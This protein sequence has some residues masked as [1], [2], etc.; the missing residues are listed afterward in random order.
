VSSCNSRRSVQSIEDVKPYGFLDTLQLMLFKDVSENIDNRKLK[1][2][3]SMQK[4]E[5]VLKEARF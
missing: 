5:G 4:S 1:V 2:V 3:S